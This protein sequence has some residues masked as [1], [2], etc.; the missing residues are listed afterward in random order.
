MIEPKVL[1]RP[2]IADFCS[3][4]RET[5]RHG[6]PRA[7]LT[8]IKIKEVVELAWIWA[9]DDERFEQHVPRPR[10]FKEIK[11]PAPKETKAATELELRRVIAAIGS[12][13][14]QR[15]LAVLLAFTGLR[16]NQA[17]RLKWPDFDFGRGELR[18]RPEL[19]KSRQERRG[20]HVPISEHLLTR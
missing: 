3:H 6:R 15:N 9:Y 20:R 17:M 12:T 16:V 19:G 8:V 14:W 7:D 18:I 13:Q 1:T 2:L 5:G 11:R 4:L 10:R